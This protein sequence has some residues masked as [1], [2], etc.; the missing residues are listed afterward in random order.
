MTTT[1][2]RPMTRAKKSEHHMRDRVL[3]G[4]YFCCLCQRAAD[5]NF[6]FTHESLWDLSKCSTFYSHLYF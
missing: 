6:I 1:T 2:V 4:L 5:I 3:I